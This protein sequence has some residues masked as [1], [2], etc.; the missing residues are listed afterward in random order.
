MFFKTQYTHNTCKMFISKQVTF[1]S[2][3]LKK[4]TQKLEHNSSKLI[5]KVKSKIILEISLE[6][7]TELILFFFT[8]VVIMNH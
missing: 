2:C 1:I 8:V 5:V 6:H 3:L 7:L 4:D